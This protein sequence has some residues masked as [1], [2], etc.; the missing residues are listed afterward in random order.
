MQKFTS[1]EAFKN[2]VSLVRKNAHYHNRPLPTVKYTGKV[3]LHG[4][5]SGDM[6]V[7]MADGSLINIE[8]IENGDYI[9]SYD[10]EKQEHVP[11]MVL[12][13]WKSESEKRWIRLIF[14]N[15]SI[16]N[17][18]EDHKF[19]TSNRGWVEAKD[20]TENDEFIADH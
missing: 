7:T 20:L 16:I 11:K 5:F 19:Y 3:K 17:C 18:T 4:C 14:D 1:I 13:T 8:D 2:T 12:N 6:P 15:N 9:L 10:I